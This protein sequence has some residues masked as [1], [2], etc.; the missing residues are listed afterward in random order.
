MVTGPAIHRQF[1]SAGLSFRFLP[2]ADGG[3]SSGLLITTGLGLYRKRHQPDAG[4][5]FGDGHRRP[6]ILERCCVF[7]KDQNAKQHDRHDDRGRHAQC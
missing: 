3:R 7:G 5:D 1:G 4:C 6:T 2:T